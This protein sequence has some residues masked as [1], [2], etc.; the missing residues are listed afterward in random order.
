MST[1]LIDPLLQQVA[2]P[3]ARDIHP[4]VLAVTYSRTPNPLHH[5]AGGILIPVYG[6]AILIKECGDVNRGVDIDQVHQVCPFAV[7]VGR[8]AVEGQK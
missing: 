5:N 6:D 2:H 3:A 1:H 7:F 8:P 4:D